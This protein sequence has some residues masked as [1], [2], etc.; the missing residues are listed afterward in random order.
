[1]NKELLVEKF[2]ELTEKY[3]FTNRSLQKILTFKMQEFIERDKANDNSLFKRLYTYNLCVN[4][5]SASEDDRFELGLINSKFY[6]VSNKYNIDTKLID[7]EYSRTYYQFRRSVDAWD[8]PSEEEKRAILTLESI[9]NSIVEDLYEYEGSFMFKNRQHDVTMLIDT[10]DE[11]G[12]FEYVLRVLDAN[13][14]D[15]EDA[16]ISNY[17]T[18]IAQVWSIRDRQ[19]KT[20]VCYALMKI[21]RYIRDSYREFLIR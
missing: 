3:E 10:I 6:N 20:E 14:D 1:M 12:L 13:N 19:T 8:F 18:F 11:I 9:V 4:S 16:I 21:N 17:G 2:N 7:N 15:D 5:L